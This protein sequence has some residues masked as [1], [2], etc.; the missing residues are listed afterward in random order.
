MYEIEN[1]NGMNRLLIV[2]FFFALAQV[3]VLMAQEKVSTTA[4]AKEVTIFA[5][6]AEVVN[7]VQANI[8][9]GSA[10]LYIQN[11][12]RDIDVNS[13]QISGP[14]GITVLSVSQGKDRDIIINNPVHQ[15]LKDS[16]DLVSARK[17]SLVNKQKAAQGALKILNNE[18]L[19]GG[20][21][22]VDV[23]DLS[24]LVDYY[25]LK[26]VDLNSS[27]ESLTRSIAEEDKVIRRL[28]EQIKRYT[29]SGGMLIVQMSNAKAYNGDLSVSYITEG[30]SWQAYYD[31]RA[32][33]V[34]S[35]L[36]ILYKAK[37]MQSTGV[38]WKN[39]KLTLS[40]GNPVQNGNA[41]I[42]SPSYA[43][44]YV[45]PDEKGY[46]LA[47]RTAA[48]MV[49]NKVQAA[50]MLETQEVG[51]LNE[52]LVRGPETTVSENQLSATFDIAVPYDI[53]SNGEPHSVTLQEYVHPA[54]FRYY[55]VPKLDKDAFLLAE[56]V[57]FEKMN[58]VSGEANI[59]FENMFV[60][61]SYINT[62][63]T[64]DTLNLSMGRDKSIN[65]KRE[66]IM[67]EKSSYNSGSSKRQTFT[68]ELRVRNGKS[69]PIQMVLKDQYPIS[70]D[71]AID[72]ELTED[73]G[74]SVNRETGILTW[75]ID[76][77]PGETKTYRF[78]Y[79][80]KHPKNRPIVVN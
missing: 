65:I 41:P 18:S 75:T 79:T 44:F 7:T 24:K 31:L 33:S 21:G 32:K 26:S 60:G 17:E 58:L 52:V 80:V 61:T 12:A 54:S 48:V 63:L 42:L 76:V 27:I 2:L 34:A 25:L 36:D 16:I 8:P 56:L 71:K 47:G 23:D 10:L 68:Y 49:R 5:Y 19:F 37:V 50:P 62:N 6:G 1:K 40:T 38:D 59:I 55:A 51:Q 30:A 35:P 14:D 29:G 73:A 20:S 70:T 74:A 77:N 43:R 22:K 57:D 9:K 28:N 39:V 72:I 15:Q 53:L 69:T 46:A 66:R 11:V 45:Q 13:V 67:D 78:T 64:S 3:N 4:V